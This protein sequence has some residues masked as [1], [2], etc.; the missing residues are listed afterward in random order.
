MHE[1]EIDGKLNY[2]TAQTTHRNWWEITLLNNGVRYLVSKIFAHAADRLNFECGQS[3]CFV[4]VSVPPCS[5]AVH[6]IFWL[7][8]LGSCILRVSLY[9]YC[10]VIQVSSSLLQKKF[11]CSILL[12]YQWVLFFL[13]LQEKLWDCV[14]ISV[15]AWDREASASRLKIDVFFASVTARLQKAHYHAVCWVRV[16]WA[17]SILMLGYVFKPSKGTNISAC[18]DNNLSSS[19]VLAW[20]IWVSLQRCALLF[21]LCVENVICDL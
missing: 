13:D 8:V 4:V 15:Q 2:S 1:V 21:H 12:F 5:L 10:V 16:D 18:F 14:M 3:F 17:F 6:C 7:N 11:E 20:K 19:T 9:K